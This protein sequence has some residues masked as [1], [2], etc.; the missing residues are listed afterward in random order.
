MDYLSKILYSPVLSDIL[1]EL[2]V[3][4][5]VLPSDIRPLDPDFVVIGYAYPIHLS[6]VN[7]C[8]PDN[9]Y[10]GILNALDNV[11]EDAVIVIEV[12][13]SIRNKVAAWGELTST[14]AMARGARG[15]V[16]HGFV[17]DAHQILRMGFPVFSTGFIPYDIKC[18][19][20]ADDYDKEVI[21]NGMKIKSGDLIFGDIN[22][23][24]IVPSELINEV[25]IRAIEKVTKESNVKKELKRG[26][27]AKEVW[28][29]YKIF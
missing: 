21:I 17:R 24:V 9:P 28:N 12:D 25:I 29:K 22:G 14:A 1:D 7:D 8:D 6:K 20:D 2:G 13:E 4:D 5:H 10:K 16:V 11:P 19:G 27:S 26:K 15:T 18:R 23:V 3:I